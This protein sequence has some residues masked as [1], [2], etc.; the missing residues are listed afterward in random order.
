MQTKRRKQQQEIKST[1][2]A[3]AWMYRQGL[4]PT[5]ATWKD[6]QAFIRT[7]RTRFILNGGVLMRTKWFNQDNQIKPDLVKKIEGVS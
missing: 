2:Q 4:S 3:F 1:S 6:K 5:E 7:L